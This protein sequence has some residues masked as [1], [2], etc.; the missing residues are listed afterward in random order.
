MN[1]TVRL[2]LTGRFLH[3]AH[4]E[5]ATQQ[6]AQTLKIDLAKATHLLQT[7]P[8]II[9]QEL[10][11]QQVEPYLQ[12]FARIG[13]EVQA[14]PLAPVKPQELRLTTC[15]R[16][17][18]TAEDPIGAASA[19]NN[20]MCTQSSD[21]LND[22]EAS[23]LDSRTP[24]TSQFVAEHVDYYT[25]PFCA[26]N[27]EGRLGRTHYII[28]L[29]ASMIPC[30]LAAILLPHLMIRYNVTPQTGS[31]WLLVL[32]IGPLVLW[33]GWQ[34]FRCV[35]LRLH[36][37]NLSGYWAV[38]F[39]A[40][41][42]ISQS[43][44][45]SHPDI[46]Y[47]LY[48]FAF[49]L[50]SLLPLAL[51]LWPGNSGDNLY[52]AESEPAE[53]WKKKVAFAVMALALISLIFKL[54]N[55]HLQ[56]VMDKA[57]YGY[58]LSEQDIQ[59]MYKAERNTVSEADLKILI[60]NE[61]EENGRTNIDREAFRQKVQL[62]WDATKLAEL[63]TLLQPPM[64]ANDLPESE[65]KLVT[66]P[67]LDQYMRNLAHDCACDIPNREINR[68]KLQQFYD[69]SLRHKRGLPIPKRDQS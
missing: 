63:R 32:T 35:A 2:E 11:A 38:P 19:A 3:D 18:D 34:Y 7:A 67:E 66:E 23:R 45:N 53:A 54:S 30:I 9:K 20:E 14:I 15:E 56:F 65:R 51:A 41:F 13:V 8:R 52:G 59:V 40:V 5:T 28:N 1:E 55:S 68:R 60:K 10:A 58:E 57:R 31:G 21:T 48:M 44:L 42:F 6:L 62:N 12:V 37:L 4:P 36:D 47:K 43:I 50:S 27:L 17:P 33:T 49:T 64:Q 24:K 69:D 61:E 46:S 22:S 26:K 29:I 16:K 25:P 39:V